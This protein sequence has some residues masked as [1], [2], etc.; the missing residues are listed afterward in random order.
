MNILIGQQIARLRKRDNV[1]QSEL[2]EYL[3][4]TPQAISKWEN[5]VST[6]DVFLLPDIAQLFGVSIDVL[7]GTSD[8]EMTQ[9]LVSKYSLKPTDKNYRDAR[10][11][12]DKLL[13]EEIEIDLSLVDLSSDLEIAKANCH[14]LKA[15]EAC[16]TVIQNATEA[17]LKWEAS[18][19]K[20]RLEFMLGE[21]SIE[22]YEKL[23]FSSK[24]NWNL[25]LFLITL[26]QFNQHNKALEVA[27]AELTESSEEAS[28][29]TYEILLEAAYQQ[30]NLPLVMKYGQIILDKW[31][32][33][34]QRFNALWMIWLTL[35]KV[36]DPTAPTY[37]AK[38]REALETLTINEFT[39]EKILT[40]LN[41][42]KTNY[43]L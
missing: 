19:K 28:L 40:K 4:V 18:V 26:N 27:E 20:L 31:D 5:G 21:A 1:S 6:P 32:D 11:A 8:Y 2:A 42:H 3:G 14:L 17:N 25:N 38:L 24:T 29:R 33:D 37:E 10:E 22:T 15:K 12:I 23:Y 43:L 7:F 9:K 36:N 41:K 35:N 34:N 30:S 13:S 16:E 39:K